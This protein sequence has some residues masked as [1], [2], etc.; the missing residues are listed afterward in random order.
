[1]SFTQ[2]DRFLNLATPLG[3][4]K[5][6]VRSFAGHEGISQLFQFHLDTLSE[7][8][9]ISFDDIVG[10]NVSFSVR[11]AE[12]SKARYFNGYVSRFEQ[13]PGGGRLTRYHVELVP[14]LWF[15]TLSADCR[16]FQNQSVPDIIQAVFKELGFTDFD[17]QLRASYEP[18]EYC[19][20]Y[21]ENAFNFVSRLMEQEGI[22]YFFK[23]EN[24]K[25]TMVLA[26]S[27]SA[28]QPCPEQSRAMLERTTG[29]GAM[30][31]D[32]V[33]YTWRN[34]N[35]MRTGKYAFTDYN[36]ETPSTNLHAEVLSQISQGGNQKFETYDHPGEYEKRN[37][38]DE[39]AKRRIE[40]EEASHATIEGESDVRT[41]V[42]GFKFD[43]TGHER[44]DQNACFVLTS[45]THEGEEGGFYSGS[46]SVTD[47]TYKNSFVA[48]KATTQFRPQRT[49]AKPL[50]HGVQTA[51]VVGPGGEEIYCDKYGRV[52][53]QFHWDR[54]GKQ[55]EKSS[56]WI[57]VAQPWAG[58]N[59]GAIM[60]P[61]INQEVVVSFLEGDPDRPLITGTVY[62]AQNV[63]PYKLPDKM[64]ISTIKSSSTKGAGNY[65]EL[66]FDDTKGK[67][68]VF[69]H[70]AYDHDTLVDHD[71]KET[72]VNDSHH[73][74]K[75]EHFECSE[76][77]RHVHVKGDMNQ[78]FDSDLSLTVGTNKQEKVGQTWASNAG[79]STTSQPPST[80]RSTSLPTCWLPLWGSA[81]SKVFD[82]L[83]R[84]PHRRC[85]LE[86]VS[87]RVGRAT[88]PETVSL[89]ASLY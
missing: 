59:W 35:L 83:K 7:D 36:F 30:R 38:G 18:W 19:V 47:S 6:L 67:E 84:H 82:L 21:R 58:N 22:F 43:L 20:Q 29:R 49:A 10:K 76:K 65:N 4:D 16:I 85:G 44:G 39:W 60:I 45:V 69:V 77:D 9:S 12:T 87:G 15:L 51:V 63:V 72:I 27:P 80:T 70:A 13:V 26:D 86:R 5:L 32:D 64:M 48:M 71:R 11:L 73:L 33:V 2:K 40:E 54:R 57:R 37:Q 62:N 56:C 55:N 46:G 28:Y 68:Q 50:I 75:G 61:R 66:R 41:F 52:K 17:L 14:W 8:N 53:V 88:S 23:H 78:K 24:G 74:V 81:C 79:Q 89:A 1:M 3:A 25:H 31:K 34:A 42:S